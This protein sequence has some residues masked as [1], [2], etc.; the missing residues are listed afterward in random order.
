MNKLKI[1]I[2][3]LYGA[4]EFSRQL[5]GYIRFFIIALLSPRAKLAARLLASESQ[6]AIYTHRISQKK[7]PRPSFSPAFRFLWATLSR[8]WSGWR[9]AAHLMQPATVLKWHRQGF[10][11]YWRWKFRKRG[12]PKVDADMRKLI[13]QLSTEN[14]LWS[15]ERIHDHLVL[16]G[17]DP[18]NP[19]T[20]RKYM[21]KPDPSRG[22]SQTWLTFIRNHLHESWAIDF[23]TVPTLAFK[24][25]YV[26]V[27]LDHSKRQV[28][29]FNITRY[30]CMDWVILQLKDAMPFDRQPRFLFRDN[31]GIYGNGVGAFLT[32]CGIEEVR[33]AYHSPWQNP[34]VERF[35]GTLRRELLNHIVPINEKHCYR[36]IK[37]Y[38]EDYYHPERPH[39]G[40]DGDTPVPH[41]RPAKSSLGSE[42]HAI[43]ILGGLHH[44]Y[45]RAAA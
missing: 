7:E 17:F 44:K 33:T 18:P 45:Q 21:V 4:F 38:I 19:D 31:D 12:R 9:S 16:L 5:F 22:S 36:L 29:H 40:L 30:P 2:R 28:L 25:L 1:I 27:I 6:L 11:L 8:Y 15:A 41:P 42:L 10:R 39:M 20:I 23:C 14:R 3:K 43:P 37:E 24:V 26:F 35:F 34:F 13:K 32:M